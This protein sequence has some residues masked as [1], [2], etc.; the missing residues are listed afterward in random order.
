MGEV[1]GP[2]L[3]APLA[4]IYGRFYIYHSANILFICFS[5]GGGTSHNLN[6]LIAFRFLNGLSVASQ[7]LNPSIVG[8][9]FVQEERGRPLSVMGYTKLLGPVLGPIIGGYLS[10]TKGWRWTFWFI[11][12]LAGALEI[13]FC[14][15]YR[16]T[17][18]VKI[19]RQK[20][21]RLQKETHNPHLISRYD[22][23]ISS[24]G[25]IKRA[26]FRPFRM[27]ITS[28]IIVILSFYS[29]IVYG[30]LF[31]VLTTIT[32][33]FETE[34]KFSTGPAGLSFLGIGMQKCTLSRTTLIG[35]QELACPLQ[36]YRVP[37]L[38]IGI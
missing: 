19:V 21:K 3:L 14:I 6:T 16:E 5:I 37:L 33:V 24:K 25:F 27:L 15:L 18:K 9:L 10:Q 13:A 22:V 28:P 26:I 31:L 29:A 34:Y 7:T 32:E 17:Y 30:S 11:V 4:E 8:D 36:S 12:I 35:L 20:A 2:L 23:E 1:A 38:W